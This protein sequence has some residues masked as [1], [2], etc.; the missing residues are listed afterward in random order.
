MN[1]DLGKKA[2]K[3]S[4]KG[5]FKLMNNAVLVKTMKSVRKHRYIKLITTE[6]RRNYL[7][8]QKLY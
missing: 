7:V 6:Q 1:T 4:E 2:K 8:S 3:D 5:L